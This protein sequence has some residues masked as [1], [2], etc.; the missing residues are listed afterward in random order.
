MFGVMLTMIYNSLVCLPAAKLPTVR[1]ALAEL[2]GFLEK[3]EPEEIKYV[4]VCV[5]VW[6]LCVRVC[7]VCVCVCVA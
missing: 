2:H 6:S 7:G 5:S 3:V 1:R 4:C